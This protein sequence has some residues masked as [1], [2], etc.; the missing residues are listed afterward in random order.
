M[1]KVGQSAHERNFMN[2]K[3][4]LYHAIIYIVLF[5]LAAALFL[6]GPMGVLKKDRTVEGNINPAGTVTV[7]LEQQVQQ[8]F[9]AEG[10]YLRYLDIYVTSEES[11]DKDYRLY[12]YN[13]DN[14]VLINEDIRTP[15]DEV[16]G[17]VRLPIGI[18][19]VPGKMYVWQLKATA[20]AGTSAPMDLA[21]M[22]T[23][24]T[25]L[26]TFG[27]WY[28]VAD[29]ES[30]MQE[31]QNIIM[32]LTYTDA[33]SLKKSAVV[34]GG[35]SG[36]AAA[37]IC[38]A[39]YQ[40]LKK[41]KLCRQVRVQTTVILTAGPAIAALGVYLV[42][43]VFVQNL[44]GGEREDKI[45][46]GLGIGLAAVY[47]AW[48]LFAKRRQTR[49]EPLGDLIA[50]KGMDWLQ[51]LTIAGVLLGTTHF[52]NAQFQVWQDLAYREV[53]F[54]IG[55]VLLTMGPAKA[56]CNKAGAVWTAVS[57]AAGLIFYVIK[58]ATLTAE[59]A[60]ERSALK[61]EILIVI[62]GGL[63]VLSLADK[64][65]R[66][67]IDFKTVNRWYAGLLG[68][69]MLLLLVFSNTRG[70]PFYL[71][72]VFTLFYVF[73]L[74]WEKRGHLLVNFS[75]AVILHFA[76]ATIF[77]LARRPYRSWYFPRYNHVFHTVTITA[78][79]LTLVICVL[80][81][82][83]LMLLH[84]RK[85][86]GGKKGKASLIDMWGT[87]L[88]FGMA[89]AFLFFTLS[90]TGY[91][92]VA[93]MLL[94]VVP[95]G[96]FFVYRKGIAAFLKT[97]VILAAAALLA[98]PVTYSGV[99]LLPALYNDPYIYEVED[100]SAA[101]HKDDPKDSRAYIWLSYFKYQMEQ[102]LF[103][104]ASSETE[105]QEFML[106]LKEELYVRPVSYLVASGEELTGLEEFSNGRFD[107]FKSYI[108]NWNLTGHDEM[109][110]DL[111]NGTISV[112]AHNTY[113]QV[114]HDHGLIVGA[115]F[116]ILGA[117]SACQMFRF[118]VKRRK[119]DPA[120]LV[121]IAVVIGFAVAGLVEWLF[122][123]CNPMG[124]SVML[125]F[126]PLLTFKGAEEK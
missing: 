100:S 126:A 70:W 7:T 60:A 81:A 41:K 73:Y 117:V 8:V 125:I 53:L 88:L 32:R 23:G 121:P 20:G 25:G 76:L 57:A 21:Y 12:L 16:P 62:A 44:F 4:K 112:H 84:G 124:F 14:D 13:E 19:T 11:L 66:K 31:A 26:T 65:R 58:S 52:M 5:Y 10:S 51:T 104:D 123:P 37:L 122:H 86:S 18:E 85:A 74:G 92:A 2:R 109:G 87:L 61:Y 94:I 59:Q 72:I 56:V 67:T 30:V 90:R 95:F 6:L 69:F 118:A 17:Y 97:V 46:Y 78:Y 34:Y 38:L 15:I 80:T 114:I 28:R 116:V 24:E 71:V 68:V 54:W 102:K 106:C 55:L 96:V 45:V 77:V 63:V 47:F 29:G 40:G 103:S 79:Y 101:V 82:R 91:L 39:L 115:L 99:R 42:Y 110:V 50:Q 89:M 93:A 43:A 48:V 49:Q 27:N 107:I 119:E 98:L 111:P 22:N 1:G 120:A 35:L 36:L 3:I 33:P 75:N 64:I 83:L 108:Q 113:L 105:M 9:V